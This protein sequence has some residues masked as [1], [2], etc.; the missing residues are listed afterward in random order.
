M[1]LDDDE[2]PDDVVPEPLVAELLLVF[3]PELELELVSLLVVELLLSLALVPVSE[4]VSS[5][6]ELLALSLKAMEYTL[7]PSL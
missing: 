4:D 2:L 1:L 3:E 6:V 5:L 7:K